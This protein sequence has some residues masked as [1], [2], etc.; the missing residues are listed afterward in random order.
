MKL[1]L[2]GVGLVLALAGVAA[3][4]AIGAMGGG[5]SVAPKDAAGVIT[6]SGIDGGDPGS[7]TIDVMSFSWGAS[8][9]FTGSH[10]GGGGAG[11]ASFQDLSITKL[12]DKASPMLAKACATGQHIQTV[13]LNV[14][15]PNGPK[16]APFMQYKLDDVFVT[17]V[18][19]GGSGGSGDT[20][21]TE[22]VSFAYG[23]IKQTYTTADGSETSFNFNIDDNRV[24]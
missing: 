17:S 22:N 21:P 9:T 16:G 4:V 5:I 11:K 10:G 1:K 2:I 8:N 23:S 12:V 19:Q 7:P 20:K 3:A 15:R 14:N 18:S 13:I 6:I 24:G